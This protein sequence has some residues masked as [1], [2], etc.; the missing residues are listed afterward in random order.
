MV[1]MATW[2]MST[3]HEQRP[4]EITTS[5]DITVRI[6]WTREYT[7]PSA[8][9]ANA[10]HLDRGI[11]AE[12][13]GVPGSED[14][15]AE[16]DYARHVRAA[17]Q[18]RPVAVDGI[19][20][21]DAALDELIDTAR[22][23]RAYAANHT[24]R[25]ARTLELL[26]AAAQKCSA[27]RIEPEV[28]HPRWSAMQ[29]ADRERDGLVVRALTDGLL[30]QDDIAQA[31]GLSGA[32]TARLQPYTAPTPPTFYVSLE[33]FARRIGVSESTIKSYR[34]RGL[35]PEPD[36][37]LGGSPGWSLDTADKYQKTRRGQGF[38]SD[39]QNA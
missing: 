10:W 30:S 35:L 24:A 1:G 39:L 3:L 27:A 17:W 37:T 34:S 29:D 25:A 26:R 8:H 28:G 31:A 11:C 18:R 9:D 22:A 36:I 15:F 7:W 20:D 21:L 33:G 12:A 5:D 2:D 23:Y 32:Q 16:V 38:R 19:T 13:V 6:G 4:A 14:P